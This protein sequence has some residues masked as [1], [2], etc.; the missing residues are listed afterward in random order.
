LTLES[1]PS[2]EV[3]ELTIL[4]G[5]PEGGDLDSLSIASDKE[6]FPTL[7]HAYCVTNYFF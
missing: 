5:P 3:I 1:T 4:A 6:L 7:K 2:I